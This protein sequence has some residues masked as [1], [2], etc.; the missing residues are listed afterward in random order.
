MAGRLLGLLIN[1][2]VF[3]I[4]AAAVGYVFFDNLPT[5]VNTLPYA[6]MDG[7]NTLTWL[8]YI[9]AAGVFVFVFACCWNHMA[10][11]QNEQDQVI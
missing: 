7:I 10:Q 2:I 5:F 4:M 9:F 1:L 6:S 8:K 11:S 3:P